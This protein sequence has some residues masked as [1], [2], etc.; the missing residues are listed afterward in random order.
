[1]DAKHNWWGYNT[2]LA[3][4]GRVKERGDQNDLLRVEY[5]PFHY[6]N[7][8][9]LDVKCPPAWNLVGDTC[10]IYIGAPMN[11]FQAREFCTVSLICDF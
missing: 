3:V 5:E 8:S 4:G 7:R 6:N 9:L 1:M 2:S 11:F 10:Y